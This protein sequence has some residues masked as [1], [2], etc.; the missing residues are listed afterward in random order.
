VI[1]D[2]PDLL[3]IVEE[4]GAHQQRPDRRQQAAL[5]EQGRPVPGADGCEGG[6]REDQRPEGGAQLGE[7]GDLH[8]TI[9]ADGAAEPKQHKQWG[10]PCRARTDDQRI[11]SPML[12]QLS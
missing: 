10:R 2:E 12:Y 11:K 9:L 6:E 4:P 8:R 7:G 3:V 5:G 1:V